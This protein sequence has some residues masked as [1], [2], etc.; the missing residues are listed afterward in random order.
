LVRP[1]ADAK[2]TG[3]LDVLGIEHVPGISCG[4]LWPSYERSGADRSAQTGCPFAMAVR[5]LHGV[6]DGMARVG[7]VLSAGGMV[8][9]A[10]HAGVLSALEE[11]TGWDPRTADVI[12]GTSAGSVVA[13]MLRAGFSA[14]D[15]ANRARGRP[16]SPAGALLEQKASL[17]GARRPL[18]GP[19]GR[20]PGMA[21]PAR[22]ARALWEPWR[23]GPGSLVAAVL[24]RGRSST[25]PVSAPL[26]GLYGSGWPRK[27]TWITAV[28]LDRGRRVVFGRPGAPSA[29]IADA[30]AASCAIPGYFE[31][32][33]IDGVRYVDGG[34]HTP[35]NADVLAEERLDLVIVSSPMSSAFGTLR[36]GLDLPVRQAVGLALTREV[37]ALRRR[38]IRVTIFQPTV[39]DQR[40]M[41]GNPLDAAKR[42]P[43]CEQVQRSTRERLGRTSER[44]LVEMLA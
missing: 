39:A 8:G 5:Q 18:R 37:A 22:V 40:V 21:S 14:A 34:A 7:L 31:P 38:G 43:V 16:I 12:V 20:G 44:R 33:T 1:A 17:G 19:A 23:V 29:A 15:V 2:A 28:E 4:P 10:F 36:V 13:A 41:A 35:S 32:V 9:H 30:V 42:A 3:S 25:D 11:T 26:R 27:P 24:P 6:R